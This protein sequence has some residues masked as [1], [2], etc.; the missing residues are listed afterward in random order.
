VARA[1]LI[2]PGFYSNEQLSECSILARYVFPGLWM[3]ADRAGR[4]E[5]RPKRIKGELLRYDDGDMDGLLCE[6]ARHGL[7]TRYVVDGVSLIQIE[8][9]TKH[10]HCHVNEPASTLPERCKH[11]A[12]TVQA[13]DSHS[14]TP[15]KAE[16]VTKAESLPKAEAK[17]E[18]KAEQNKTVATVS[19]KTGE[20]RRAVK[21]VSDQIKT[22]RASTWKSY[23]DAYFHRY[24]VEPV[25]NQTVNSQVANLCER[26][27]QD[28]PAVAANY[29]RSNSTFYLTKG[30]PVGLLL[31]DCEKLRTEWATGRSVTHSEARTADKQQGNTFGR[32]VD[33]VKDGTNG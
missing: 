18:A 6:L 22:L 8:T 15:A 16:A 10:Q 32:L 1:R 11:G 30:Y 26:I 4:L 31:A 28:A 14:A 33:R 23:S 21:V 27:G 7:I 12:S 3:L 2:K 29:L 19:P 24:G 9:F 17:A 5:D 13:P 20:P 25:R